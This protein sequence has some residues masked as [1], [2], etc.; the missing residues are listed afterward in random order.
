[1][2]TEPSLAR[3]W[4]RSVAG[5]FTALLLL[6]GAL[7]AALSW[8]AL[9]GPGGPARNWLDL[10]WHPGAWAL[11][12]DDFPAGEATDLDVQEAWLTDP[13]EDDPSRHPAITRL[14]GLEH[15]SWQYYE[16]PSGLM[17][18]GVQVGEVE[19]FTSVLVSP[20]GEHFA[21]LLELDL[22][23]RLGD[24]EYA[25]QNRTGERPVPLGVT[26]DEPL[27][28]RPALGDPV[29]LGDHTVTTRDLAGRYVDI[30]ENGPHGYFGV[31]GSTTDD[32]SGEPRQVAAAMALRGEHLVAIGLSAPTSADVDWEAELD[33]V[34]ALVDAKM[35]ADPDG[36]GVT[37]F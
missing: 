17:R 22:G 16:H 4:W 12:A 6:L 10:R 33:R 11:T 29:H 18:S 3:R 13:V 14:P 36:N 34:V 30:E 27:Y 8:G 25:I 32:V 37:W 20:R 19:V 28:T 7:G 23:H 31:A 24:Y 2:T 5:P 15:L 1:M 21:E 9:M 35:E 26:T